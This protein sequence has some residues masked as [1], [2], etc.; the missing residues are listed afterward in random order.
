VVE[1]LRQEG[2]KVPVLIYSDINLTPDMHQRVL[3]LKKKYLM[4]FFTQDINEVK[5]FCKM[6]D[7]RDNLNTML[8]V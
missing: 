5:K 2:C 7:M 6:E 1:Y 4:L 8:K 3:Q